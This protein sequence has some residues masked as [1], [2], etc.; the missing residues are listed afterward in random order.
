MSAFAAAPPT[1]SAAMFECAVYSSVGKLPNSKTYITAG[2]FLY[3][4]EHGV[5]AYHDWSKTKAGTDWI[6]G[7]KQDVVDEMNEWGKEGKE[8]TLAKF[9]EKVDGCDIRYGLI[10]KKTNLKQLGVELGYIKD[11]MA[12]ELPNK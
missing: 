1:D 3:D 10:N 9:K 5:K 8:A 2:L 6:L 11:P 12:G 7:R 4:K